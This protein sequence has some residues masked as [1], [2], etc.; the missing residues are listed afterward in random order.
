MD[1]DSRLPSRQLVELIS[2]ALLDS[3]LRDR[4]FANPEAIAQAFGLEPAEA[5]MV[6]RLDR[7]SLEARVAA[8][9]SG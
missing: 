3:E 2:R 7:Q 5:E 6:K 9:R 4:L 8:L 1:S